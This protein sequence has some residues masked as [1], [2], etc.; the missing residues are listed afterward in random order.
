MQ[1]TITDGANGN[2]KATIQMEQVLV[3]IGGAYKRWNYY[4][5]TARPTSHGIK[6]QS[7]L[8]T[9]LVRSYTLIFPYGKRNSR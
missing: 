5:L 2:I 1:I 4:N 9:Q 8:R 7:P 3:E 6:L